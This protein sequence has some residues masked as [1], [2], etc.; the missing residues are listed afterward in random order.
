MRIFLRGRQISI[1]DV[2][3]RIIGRGRLFAAHQHSCF[4]WSLISLQCPNIP[5]RYIQVTKLSGFLVQLHFGNEAYYR[6]IPIVLTAHEHDATWKRHSIALYT[7]RNAV[8][9]GFELLLWFEFRSSDSYCIFVWPIALSSDI[10][11]CC[12]RFPSVD[13]AM[14]KDIDV[15]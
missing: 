15:L 9:Y 5:A 8:I 10:F 12:L 6:K 7:P 2:C 14:M 11:I 3:S 13:R 4:S 1:H